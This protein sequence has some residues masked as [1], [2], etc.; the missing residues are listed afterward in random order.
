MCSVLNVTK[1]NTEEKFADEMGSKGLIR[2][3]VVPNQVAGLNYTT[4][5]ALELADVPDAPLCKPTQVDP[6]VECVTNA[7]RW[8]RANST[9]IRGFSGAGWFTGAAVLK[10]AIASKSAD[11]SVPLGL[12]RSSWGGTRVEE[13]SGPSAIAAC[14]PQT[15]AGSGV[16]TL[17]ANMIM[18]FRGLSF[19]AYTYYQGESNVGADAPCTGAKYYSC[20]LPAMLR[21]LRQALDLPKL[22]IMG[23]ARGVLQRAG[24]RDVPHMV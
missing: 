24:F 5:P 22:P 14:P 4:T 10:A 9:T 21:D 19:R 17:W 12:L 2:L 8:T 1:Q 13:W 18:P 20:A 6:F 11:A 23:G 15:G 16:S 3:M 7:L